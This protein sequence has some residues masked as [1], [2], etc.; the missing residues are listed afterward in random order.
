MSVR[1][2][3]LIFLFIGSAAANALHD[4]NYTFVRTGFGFNNRVPGEQKIDGASWFVHGAYQVPAMPL[5]INAGYSFGRVDK[6]EIKSVTGAQSVEIDGS[7]YYVGAGVVLRP[8]ERVHMIPS[9][10]VGR[11]RNCMVAD[12]LAATNKS[13]ALASSLMFRYQPYDGLWLNAGYVQ[14]YYLGHSDHEGRPGYL[15]A[16]SEYQLSELWGLGINYQGN[17]DRYATRLYLKFFL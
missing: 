13:T 16:G 9:L 11:V 8:A 14:Q 4:D 15:T 12:A 1:Q 5:V 10:T 3:L 7:S 6:G 17:A 2:P